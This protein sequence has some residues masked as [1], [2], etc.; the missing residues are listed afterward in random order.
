MSS[1]SVAC[2]GLPPNDTQALHNQIGFLS[3]E[4][5]LLTV[6]SAIVHERRRIIRGRHSIQPL[7]LSFLVM[8]RSFL[9]MD[10]TPVDDKKGSRF[11]PSPATF[12]TPTTLM[13]VTR[14]FTLARVYMKI[15]SLQRFPKSISTISS[16]I[17][18]LEQP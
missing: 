2:S 14:N 11:P 12:L 4:I 17:S 10:D 18:S 1:C 5:N 9:D 16:V 15:Q 6:Q 7:S 3:E 13:T 8:P